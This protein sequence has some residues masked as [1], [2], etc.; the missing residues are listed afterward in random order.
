M[1]EHPLDGRH[2]EVPTRHQKDYRGRL[3]QTICPSKLPAV[4]SLHEHGIDRYTRIKDRVARHPQPRQLVFH[5]PMGHAVAFDVPVC[6]QPEGVDL[7][8]GEAEKDPE[9]MPPA[10][11]VLG[12]EVCGDEMC[13]DDGVGPKCGEKSEERGCIQTVE[14]HPQIV[15][16]L[17]TFG[18]RVEI[19]VKG[20]T[21]F[22]DPPVCPTI[23][24]PR[25]Q[26]RNNRADRSFSRQNQDIAD[27]TPFRALLPPSHGPSPLW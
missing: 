21:I 11:L 5:L 15:S 4:F 13:A 20:G 1:I 2:P 24:L 3:L 16:T 25:G 19:P 14:P 27:G 22:G 18:S 26:T 17:H 8:V 23:E 7:I 12:R 9:I 6:D 10:L